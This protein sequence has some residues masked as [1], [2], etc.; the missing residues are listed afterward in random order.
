MLQRG[1]EPREVRP[2]VCFVPIRDIAQQTHLT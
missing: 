2:D 1:V